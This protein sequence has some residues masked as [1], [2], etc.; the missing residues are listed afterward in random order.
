MRVQTQEENLHAMMF[1][2]YINGRNGRVLLT[3]I[4]APRVEWDSPVAAFA[5]AY[6]HEKH[7][8][9]CIRALVKQARAR[10]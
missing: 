3:K 8:S 1:F 6:K 10:G 4:E 2:D 9:E 5:E 7:I